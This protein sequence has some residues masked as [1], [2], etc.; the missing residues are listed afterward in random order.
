MF[1]AVELEP[2][3]PASL[4][5]DVRRVMRGLQAKKGKVRLIKVPHEMFFPVL[6][7]VGGRFPM[8]FRPLLCG[9]PIEFSPNA[10]IHVVGVRDDDTNTVTNLENRTEEFNSWQQ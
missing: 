2:E 6:E 3:L 7:K 9:V 10:A 8:G 1:P 5:A 4:V